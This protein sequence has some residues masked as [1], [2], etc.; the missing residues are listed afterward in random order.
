MLAQPKI[1]TNK[2]ARDHS[3]RHGQKI[4][5]I[6]IHATAGVDPM[7]GGAGSLGWLSGNPNGT[8]IH[9]LIDK[10]GECWQMVD[11]ARAAHHV[12]FSRLV[13]NN[14]VYSQFSKF[15]CNDITLGIELE[16]L[17][18][19][20]DPYPES[21]L[22]AAAWW[23]Q[24]WMGVHG[25]GQGD[26][27]MH[28]DI[29]TNGKTDARGIIVADILRFL[30]PPAPPTSGTAMSGDSPLLSAPHGTPA[31]GAAYLARRGTDKSY[32]KQDQWTIATLYWS[33]G[34]SAGID[35]V[36][37]FAQMVHETG[38]LTSWW[39]LR[40]NRNPAGLGVTGE[41][42]RS[43]S[44]PGPDWQYDLNKALWKRG[45]AFDSWD[46]AVR[47]H[48]GHLCIYAVAPGKLNEAQSRLIVFDP[49]A[50]QVPAH[51]RGLTTWKDLEGK[52]AVPGDGYADKIAA[53]AN[54]VLG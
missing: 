18:D 21:Q 54:S 5:K 37:A 52:W 23:V 39:S 25:L 41:T 9:V 19:G 17:N 30:D 13:L 43:R 50:S 32:T 27:I 6:V 34:I 46:I 8:S 28:R 4:Q 48:V 35:P 24:H 7:L 22:R 31:Q 44:R 11:D 29:D 3:D 45:H 36:M 40:P 1:N 33:I 20:K 12:G 14:V 47:A 15:N 42:N 16:N 49:R 51:Y 38:G 26:V 2:R 53:I 10:T